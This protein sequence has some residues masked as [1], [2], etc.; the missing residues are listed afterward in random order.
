MEP[1]AAFSRRLHGWWIDSHYEG[2]VNKAGPRLCETLPIKPEGNNQEVE[3]SN[4]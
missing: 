3:C 2:M 4:P 1:D